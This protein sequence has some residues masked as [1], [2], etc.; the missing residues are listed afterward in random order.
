[1]LFPKKPT[2]SSKYSNFVRKAS[3]AEHKRVF[4]KVIEESIK[5]QQKII[6]RAKEIDAVNNRAI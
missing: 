4:K 6:D 2:T 5:A 1:M 3:A